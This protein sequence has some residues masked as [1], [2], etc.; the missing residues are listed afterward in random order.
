MD[1][2]RG[3]DGGSQLK[4]VAF[5][6]SHS[7]AFRDLNLD[8]IEEYFAIEELDR[9]HLNFPRES[10]IDSGGAIL[11]AEM[12]GEA[13]GCCGLLRHG[14]DVYEVSKMAVKRGYRGCG[15]GAELL[16]A[17]I[18]LARSRGARRLEII[19]STRLET[20]LRLYRRMGFVEVPLDTDVY[21]RGN[22]ALALDLTG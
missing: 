16:G 4:I 14:D 21:A 3:R 1:K 18:T 19:S 8:W 15:I 12:D 11:M 6:S 22:I 10:F 7:N 17:I 13:V 20:A 2:A 5:A 9:K